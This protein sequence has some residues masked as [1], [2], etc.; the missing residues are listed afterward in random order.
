MTT[1]ETRLEVRPLVTADDPAVIDLL[2]V[3]LGG[4]PTGG[5]TA[6]FFAWKHR[7]NP[8]GSS[9]GLVAVHDGRIVG[10][11]LFMRWAL[12]AGDQPIKALRAVDTATD[13]EFQGRGIFRSLTLGLLEQL[14]ASG[15]VDVVFN[16]PNA[17]SRPGYLKMGWQP[18]G[19]I[20]VRLAP[21]R[22]VRFLR[23]VRAA[24]AMTAGAKK[25]AVSPEGSRPLPI[26]R[27]PSATTVLAER[28]RDVEELLAAAAPT[29]RIHT[30]LSTDYLS[31]RYASAPELD[32][33]AVT[34]ERGGSLRGLAFGR[35]RLRGSLVE[36]TLADALVA[37][38]D[39]PSARRLLRAARAS[40][41]DHVAAHT[42]EGTEVDRAA[43]G[44]GYFRLPGSGIGL[45]ANPRR[46]TAAATLDPG[47]WR[48]SLGDLEVF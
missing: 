15:D 32:Y 11:R 39:V 4:G 28:R 16:T 34:V 10:V 20:P 22:P 12:R 33:R 43:V 35:V 21:L 42:S 30:P 27:L 2:R 7:D 38:G 26:C 19:T 8:F 24:S 13:P 46:P 3:A 45:V 29:S 31:W 47:S 44:A 48:L 37:E 41:A 40:A 18:V 5:R 36:F 17:A 9:P 23:G 1:M 6:A 25:A 14:E